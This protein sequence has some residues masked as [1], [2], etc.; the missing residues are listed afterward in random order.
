MLLSAPC[1][2]VTDQPTLLVTSHSSLLG[3]F[4]SDSF[5]ISAATT[6]HQ[7]GP[8]RLLS[9]DIGAFIDQTLDMGIDGFE[10]VLHLAAHSSILW[11]ISPRLYLAIMAFSA[12]STIA[13]VKVRAWPCIGHTS[14]FERPTLELRCLPLLQT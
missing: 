2:C 13:M 1:L 12:G 5:F 8:D 9:S 7:T 14:Q 6:P 10:R 11:T 4:A 3:V